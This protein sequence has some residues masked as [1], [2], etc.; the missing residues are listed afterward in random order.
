MGTLPELGLALSEV[1]TRNLNLVNPGKWM[2]S[3]LPTTSLESIPTSC[4]RTAVEYAGNEVLH[5]RLSNDEAEGNI[6]TLRQ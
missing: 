1:E 3:S 4:R 5:P 2:G 6:S